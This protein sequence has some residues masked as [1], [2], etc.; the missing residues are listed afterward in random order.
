MLLTCAFQMEQGQSL[1]FYTDSRCAFHIC[2]ITISLETE[3]TTSKKK[4]KNHGHAKSL[5]SPTT[6]RIIHCWFHQTYSSI[7]SQGNK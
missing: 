5:P 2:C 1:N 6:I 7:I 3:G 4:K